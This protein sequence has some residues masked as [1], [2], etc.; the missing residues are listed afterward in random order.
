MSVE[1]PRDVCVYDCTVPSCSAK[2]LTSIME[3][4][5][6][7]P[8]VAGR[9]DEA[10]LWLCKYIIF[11]PLKCNLL[12]HDPTNMA[13][14][15]PSATNN[16][17]AILISHQAQPHAISRR[18]VILAHSCRATKVQP[19]LQKYAVYSCSPSTI[20]LHDYPMPSPLAND[21]VRPDRQSP[22][23]LHTWSQMPPH[24]TC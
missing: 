16:K 12:D 22:S 6:F 18:I 17:Q 5:P 2:A 23:A 20:I 8:N 9:W 14:A 11:T 4:D 3:Y 13:K 1:A 21:A 10:G 24:F 19:A 15:L 7:V